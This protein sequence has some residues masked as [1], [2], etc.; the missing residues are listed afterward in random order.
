MPRSARPLALALSA[1]L[2][3]GCGG[4]SS[5]ETSTTPKDPVAKQAVPA[6]GQLKVGVTDG[7]I[8][9]AVQGGQSGSETLP[10]RPVTGQSNTEQGVG[11]GASCPNTDLTPSRANVATVAAST[12]CLLNGE[13]RDAGLGPLSQNPKLARAAV[14][15]SRDMVA[16]RYFDHVAKSGSDPVKRIRRAGYMPPVGAWT[17]GE[18]LA[19]GT[20]VL[21]SPKEIVKAWMKSQG[22]RQNIL[23][24]QFKEIGFGVVIG[25]PR[26]ASGAGATYTTTFGGITGAK[27]ARTAKAKKVRKGRR[28]SR[29]ARTAKARAAKART[30]RKNKN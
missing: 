28:S 3:A 19:W 13:R 18:N 21:A 10:N 22:H 30:S 27:A 23:R 16:K 7:G 2:I 6:G 14:A 12:L 20:G 15:H 25:N 9:T 17:V 26:S 8:G 5:S 4:S 1:A 24:A 11:A 29:K